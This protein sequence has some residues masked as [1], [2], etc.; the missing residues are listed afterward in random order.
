MKRLRYIGL[1]VLAILAIGLAV[2]YI[3]A[4]GYR[5]RIQSAL[6][7]ALH[8]KVTV[9]KVR[10][11]L[12]T[13]PGFA[14][15]D[16]TI[17][18]DTSIGIEPI[19][20]VETLD[21]RVRLTTLW[22]R[23][24]SFSTLRLNNP[25]VNLAKGDNG[26][27]NFQLLMRDAVSHG[28]SAGQFPS[29]Q[30]RSGRINFKFG[31]YKTIFYL[32]DADLDVNP[33]GLDR[34]DVR[35][36]GQPART[37]HAAENFGLLLGR[38]VWKRSGDGHG[39]VD[40]NLELERSGISDLARLVEGH[41]IGVHGIVASRMHVSGALD[42]L[43]VA[44][45]LHLEDVHRWDL[46]P[47]TSGG[48]D[49][50]FRGS[51][52]LLAQQLELETDRKQE[53]DVPFLLRFRASEYLKNPKW[54]A[55]LEVKDAPLAPFIEVARHMGA[56][57]PDGFSADG[58]VSG[59]IGYSLPG[60]VQG[61]FAMHDS[62]VRLQNAP[63]L[64]IRDAQVVI[65]GN[66]IRVGPS[67]VD[68]SEGQTAEIQA[69]YDADAG[70]LEVDVTTRGMN[71]SE[72]RTGSGRLLG[73][74]AIPLL[75]A[76][77]Q[78]TLRGSLS[79]ARD[80][81]SAEWSGKF[82]LHGAR[83]DLGGMREP[84]GIASAVVEVDGPKVV[85]TQMK[86]RAG[87]IA[88]SGEYRLV[89]PGRPAKLK[90]DIPEADLSEVEQFLLPTL[91]RE[92]GLLA[93]LRIRSQRAPEWLRSRRLDATLAIGK[94]TAGE[95]VW[96][97]SKARAEWNGAT[98]KITGIEAAQEEAQAT[99]QITVD[100]AGPLPRYSVEG[101]VEDFPYHGGALAF[102][103][104]VEAVGTGADILAVAHGSG[105]FS[106]DRVSLPP[107]GE[108]RAIAGS[109]ELLAGRRLKLTAIQASQGGDS[110]SG[111]GG[112]QT[113]GRMLLELTS[114]KRVVRVA[115]AK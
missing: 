19:A 97:V 37:D 101:S 83:L 61:Q 72:L 30:V 70:A 26:I 96:S 41:A 73:A 12:L 48:W 67:T 25:S 84:L 2:P 107:E 65:D 86:G 110:Y 27:W 43:K 49:L 46:L 39:Q 69:G 18:E 66:E 9:G 1:G 94:L 93:R 21:A 3:D 38:G 22:T 5:E 10:F 55:M 99:G 90:L 98:I 95:Q 79:Y 75:E 111:L 88:F 16:V 100:L 57:L 89:R 80:A 34:L 103:G 102:D 13:G 63:P 104:T 35:F 50:K 87:T 114:G 76:C 42:H 17:G 112:T 78:G 113:D 106:G 58:R 31:D 60:G 7:Q 32:T 36:S 54:A 59:L 62:S 105:T 74:G 81:S 47:P 24:L 28:A 115:L 44:G 85:L 6:E 91:K 11:N 71:V 53:P 33:V 52:D 4:T 20:Y 29:I 23:S 64:N 14:V 92:A 77:R 82:E 109:F 108:F 51:A 56:V 68:L 45:E 40:A 15:D 8:R